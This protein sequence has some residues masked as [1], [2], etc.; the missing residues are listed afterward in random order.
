MATTTHLG[1]TLVEQSQAQKEITVN[2]A[3]TR[4]D[5]L[6]NTGARSRTTNTPPVSPSAG[7]LYIVGTSPTGA[8]AGQS[9]KIAY[10]D[11]L[12]KFI[13]PNEGISWWVNDE[14]KQYVFDGTNWIALIANDLGALEGLATTGVAVRSATDTWVTR[15]IA[16]GTGISIS[17][18]SGVGGN[19]TVTLNAGHTELN[20]T[21][22]VSPVS[23]EILSY[24]GGLWR[25][26]QGM[27]VLF[28]N[29]QSGTTYTLTAADSGKVLRFTNASSITL[30]LPNS[31][32]IGFNCVVIQCGAG[33]LTFSPA[34]GASRRN[35][36]SHTKTAGQWAVCNLQ[37]VTNSGGTAA[38]YVLSGD[39]AP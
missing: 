19:P 26:T 7:D 32:S 21:S 15:S 11:Q 6:M 16:A 36:Q 14:D 10:Y 37:V 25:N 3:F 4:I 31:L 5:A 22:I 12:W 17:N 38:E 28:Y 20:D 35:R 2:Q 23:G 18:G 1:I 27:M 13:A 33:Q 24:S 29:S 30:T 8:W 34:A 9:Q 39:T